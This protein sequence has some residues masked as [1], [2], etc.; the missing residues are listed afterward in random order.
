MTIC[1]AD[2]LGP[3]N[4]EMTRTLVRLA[5]EHSIPYAIDTYPYYTSDTASALRSGLD[6]RHALIGPGVD[7][8]HA[9]ERTHR[10]G[11]EAT[12]NLVTAYC[13]G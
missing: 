13:C 10:E 7:S 1:A 9:M 6:A 2:S 5:K 4:Y 3:C 12:L 8:S 11:I